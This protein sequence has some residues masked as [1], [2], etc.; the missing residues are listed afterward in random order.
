MKKGQYCKLE[1]G[2]SDDD[3]DTLYDANEE[4]GMSTECTRP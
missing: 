1:D 2:A 3:S 4:S